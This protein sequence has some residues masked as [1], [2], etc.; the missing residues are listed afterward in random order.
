MISEDYY[1]ILGVSRDAT[2][3][4]IKSAYRRLARQYHPD[5]NQGTTKLGTQFQRIAGA[6]AVLGSPTQRSKYDSSLGSSTATPSQAPPQAP[7]PS[8]RA[9]FA[10]SAGRP[11]T[12]L[13]RTHR[14]WEWSRWKS[15]AVI[16]LALAVMA[17][18]LSALPH[19]QNTSAPPT[20]P[21]T[22]QVASAAAPTRLPVVAPVPPTVPRGVITPGAGRLCPSGWHCADIGD[23]SAAG[24]QSVSDGTWSVKAG[25][26]GTSAGDQAHIAWQELRGDGSVSARIEGL[27]GPSSGKAAGIAIRASL[28][29]DAPWYW[30]GELWNGG[31]PYFGMICRGCSGPT[32]MGLGLSVPAYVGIGRVGNVFTV[33]SSSDGKTWAAA[34]NFMAA[35]RAMAMG[36][37]ALAGLDVRSNSSAS[38]VVAVF[39]HVAVSGPHVRS[40]PLEIFNNW[41]P[42][43]VAD[44]PADPTLFSIGTTYELEAIFDYHYPSGPAVGSIGLKA[45]NGKIYG[46]WPIVASGD[47]GYL[48]PLWSARFRATIPPGT[49]QVIDSSPSNWSHSGGEGFSDVWGSP[50][51]P[52]QP[53]QGVPL[54]GS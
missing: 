13:R 45:A 33:Y 11:A 22:T 47:S 6:Y 15:L 43:Q 26:A 38:G 27:S 3:E 12:V 21:A 36:S 34:V 1:A 35:A 42:A 18:A 53:Q 50:A 14:W 49:Y 19:F 20:P 51:G 37:T 10:Q 24:G 30:V 8:A 39:D 44:G 48:Y 9:R 31:F 54:R 32:S 7:S 40:I 23:P 41:S 52:L 5:L 46:P 2:V 16:A 25:P 17:V 28:A 29:P 4:E